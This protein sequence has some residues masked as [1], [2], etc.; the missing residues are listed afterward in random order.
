M[1][2][3]NIL[4]ELAVRIDDG[5]PVAGKDVLGDHVPQERTLAR[6]ARAEERKVSSPGRRHDVHRHAE[7]EW[8]FAAADEDGIGHHGRDS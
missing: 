5:E 8:I 7:P 3:Y 1:V 6:P 2:L 4:H